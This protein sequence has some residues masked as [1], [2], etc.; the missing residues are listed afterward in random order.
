M[1]HQLPLSPLQLTPDEIKQGSY[2]MNLSKGKY[3]R[4]IRLAAMT[5]RIFRFWCLLS[6]DK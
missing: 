4:K 3:K 5:K 1:R 6:D 2:A